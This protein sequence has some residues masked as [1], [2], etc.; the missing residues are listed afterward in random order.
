M[1]DSIYKL[2]NVRKKTVR[3]KLIE[4]KEIIIPSV[5]ANVIISY[6][7]IQGGKLKLAR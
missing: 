7:N 4:K 2:L 1:K 5:L 6:G 3:R